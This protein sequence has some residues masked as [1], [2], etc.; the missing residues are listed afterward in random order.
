MDKKEVKEWSRNYI[1][2]KLTE[3]QKAMFEAWYLD[4]GEDAVLPPDERI[5]QL[6]REIFQDLPRDDGRRSPGSFL[7]A[8]AAVTLVMVSLVLQVVFHKGN[9]TDGDSHQNILPGG[10][11]AVLTL[12]NG[13]K[14]DLAQ[15]ATGRLEAGRG[16][17]KK[18]PGQLEYF[19]D[20]HRYTDGQAGEDRIATPAGGIWQLR[21]P[22]GTQVWLNNSSSLTYPNTFEGQKQRTVKLEGE[23][24][25]EVSKDKAH[26]FVVKSAGQEVKVLGTHFNIKAFKEDQSTRTTLLEGR[27][28]VSSERS[29]LTKQLIPGEQALLSKGQMIVS[30]VSTE[31]VTAWKNG[32]FRFENTP[33]EQVMRELSRWYGIDVRYEGPLSHERLTGRI[34]RSKN[35]SKVLMALAATQTVHFRVEGRRV[36]IM[37]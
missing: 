21:L 35:I 5:E 4:T 37:K 9:L 22:D 24:Y 25:F 2:G 13:E 31:Q 15:A 30:A 8:A 11:R 27:V 7:M 26:P 33:V 18:A 36:T 6:R 34:S 14:I 29:P 20:G 17:I 10:S 12:A 28:V 1:R 16:I 19:D 23:A 32:Y 3:K